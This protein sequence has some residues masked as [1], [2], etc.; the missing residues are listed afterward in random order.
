MTISFI[1]AGPGDPDLITVRGRDRLAGADIVIWA[2]SLVPEALLRHCRRDVIVHDSK[3]MTLEEVCGVFEANPDAAIVRLHSGDTSIYSA[4][5]EQIAWCRANGR[6]FE[7]VPGV[8]SVSATAAA[9]GCELTV[10]GL[11]QTLVMTRLARRTSS[12]MP[13]TESL[14]AAANAG[15]TLALFLSVNHVDEVVDELVA[16]GSDHSVETPVIVAH[17]VTWPDERIVRTTLGDLAAVVERER[18]DATTMLLIGPALDTADH[19]RRS[20]VYDGT[21]T[22]RFRQGAPSPSTEPSGGRPPR[23]EQA[24]GSTPAPSDHG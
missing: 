19:V 17:R 24:A 9:V 21:Y 8:T 18:F 20:H 13:P 7:V 1:G 22:T 5:G 4:I 6:D 14:T 2:A 16:G 15:G 11:S 10:P 12:S 23:S 3:T